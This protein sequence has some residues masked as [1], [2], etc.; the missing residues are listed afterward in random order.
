MN[1][2]RRNV[3]HG[4][5]VFVPI[6]V[7]SGHIFDLLLFSGSTFVKYFPIHCVILDSLSAVLAIVS[8]QINLCCDSYEIC[9][10]MP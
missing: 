7:G 2:L 5:F 8:G 9:M 6:F 10:K 4:F 3:L 1:C